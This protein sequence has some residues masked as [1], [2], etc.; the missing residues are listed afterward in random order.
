MTPNRILIKTKMNKQYKNKN[1]IPSGRALNNSRKFSDNNRGRNL[2]YSVYNDP[3]PGRNIPLEVKYKSTIYST[4]FTA[5]GSIQAIDFPTQGT[6]STS[7]VGDR[8]RLIKLDIKGSMFTSNFSVL[9]RII[10]FQCKG[11]NPPG[12]PPAV[13]DILAYARADAPYL[14]NARELYDIVCDHT[15]V[16]C[17]NGD[18]QMKLLEWSCDPV[19][20]D[21]RFASGSTTV[22][23]GQMFFLAI[24]NNTGTLPYVN[25]TLW[26]EDGN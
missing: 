21:L 16:N 5:A 17:V 23:N 4:P 10:V 24:T 15:W 19:I 14:Y 9:N 13:S 6:T 18:T 2:P 20:K 1:R 12:S 7:R 22:Y 3:K 11:L 25:Y 26:F 8:C